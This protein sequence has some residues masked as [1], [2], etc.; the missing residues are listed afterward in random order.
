MFLRSVHFKIGL[1]VLVQ[2]LFNLIQFYEIQSVA[3]IAS[4]LS[5][6]IFSTSR[7]VARKA[8]VHLGDFTVGLSVALRLE[9]WFTHKQFVTQHPQ[10][11]QIDCLVVGGPFYHLRWEVVQGATQGRPPNMQNV[12]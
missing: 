12:Q 6:Q 4:Y 7:E 5:N 9:R 3:N 10:A 11:P 8:Y 2:A 1:L